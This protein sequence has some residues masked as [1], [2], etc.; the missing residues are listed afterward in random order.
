MFD[1]AELVAIRIGHHDPFE[2][3]LAQGVGL[4]LT[5]SQFLHTLHGCLKVGHVDV[6]M[7]PVFSLSWLRY[8]LEQHEWRLALA[9]QSLDVRLLEEHVNA[10][11]LGPKQATRFQVINVEDESAKRSDT[12]A[13]C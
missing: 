11:N 1:Q 2:I 13:M 5:S 6:N 8:F 12:P 4:Q 10:E 3:V 7:S 9:S